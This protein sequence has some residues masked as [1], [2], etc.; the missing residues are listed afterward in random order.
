V[1][2]LKGRVAL[3]TGGSRGIG[4]ACAMMLAR[5][6]ADVVISYA[7]DNEGAAQTVRDLRVLG[8]KAAALEADLRTFGAAEALLRRAGEILG[9]PTILVANHGIWEA[10][11]IDTMT[12]ADYDRTLDTN[13]KGTV[14]VCRYTVPG[15]KEAGWGRI[16]L[17]SSMA[18]QRGAT[19]R[20][21]YAASKG[22]IVSLVRSLARELAP[23]GILVNGVAPGWVATDMIRPLLEDE[24]RRREL[25]AKV[26]LGR[27]ALPDEIAA[28][29]L[30]LASDL[31]TY[32]CGEIVNVNG[33]A[34]L[35]G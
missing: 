23:A 35:G 12:E 15:M 7:R 4:R 22:A 19:S 9:P 30:F 3:V 24:A 14:A 34:H 26:P 1:I 10:A 28:T 17:L 29:V 5:S 2:S 31:A 27:V 16:V 6:G 21:L 32:L 33:G 8:N 18:A 25:L 13:L 11:P 20:A